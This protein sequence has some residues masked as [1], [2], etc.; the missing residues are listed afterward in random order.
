[1]I[2]KRLSKVPALLAACT[3]A[4]ALA[5]CPQEVITPDAGWSVEPDSRQSTTAL[6]FKFNTEV[7]GLTKDHF[8]LYSPGSI[9]VIDEGRNLSGSGKI[10]SLPVKVAYTSDYNP[11]VTVSINKDGISANPVSVSVQTTNPGVYN[12][13][14]TQTPTFNATEGRFELIFNQP[15]LDLAEGDIVFEDWIGKVETRTPVRIH[16]MDGREW[17]V[18]ASIT[19]E[20]MVHL[21]IV[22]EGIGAESYV[23]FTVNASLVSITSAYYQTASELLESNHIELS[24][25]QAVTGLTKGDVK[26]TTYPADGL[27]TTDGEPVMSSSDGRTWDVPVSYT[28]TVATTYVTVTKDGVKNTPYL[29]N[30]GSSSLTQINDAYYSAETGMLSVTFDA[31]VRN[32]TKGQVGIG[33]AAAVTPGAATVSGDPVMKY[34]TTWDIPL[35]VTKAGNVMVWIIGRA[36]I[37]GDAYGNDQ[38]NSVYIGSP[39]DSIG[40]VVNDQVYDTNGGG[41]FD[42][43]KSFTLTTGKDK[44]TTKP[45]VTLV[46]N[47]DYSASQVIATVASVDGQGHN[48]V[49]TLNVSPRGNQSGQLRG[50][51]NVTVD[52]ATVGGADNPKTV[53]LQTFKPTP[54]P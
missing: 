26:I 25:S 7:S 3:L 47:P 41:Y 28:G 50:Y 39:T 49:V 32:L 45:V 37:N 22:R 4:T 12:I 14:L 35:T 30:N 9:A 33:P 53:Q 46:A 2:G 1:M 5:G 34:N 23:N 29:V 6:V 13:N 16:G 17:G 38:Y 31:P 52:G 42:V 24:F 43:S 27:A 20:G 11:E 21:V 10:W 36:D 8:N 48:W 18:P 54:K 44:G 40:N 51:Y 19:D 15:L